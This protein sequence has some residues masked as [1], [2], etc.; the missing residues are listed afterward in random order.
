[1]SEESQ[2]EE[3]CYAPRNV[4]LQ[5]LTLILILAV[6]DNLATPLLNDVEMNGETRSAV[7]LLCSRNARPQKSLVGRA[8]WEANLR[9]KA[10]L[11]L[12]RLVASF[13]PE[14]WRNSSPCSCDC[15][16]L[17]VPMAPPTM[18]NIVSK[19]G[20]AAIALFIAFVSLKSCV[21]TIWTSPTE[22]TTYTVRGS[23][24][25]SLSLIFL[26]GHETLFLYTIESSNF[27]EAALTQ[28]RGTYGTHYFWRLWNIEGPG[29]AGGLFGYR[30]YPEGT[31]PV[32]ME[33]TVVKKF[34]HGTVQPTLPNEGE[35]TNP[36]ILFSDNAVHFG[37]MSLVKEPTDTNLV[38][39]L[40]RQLKPE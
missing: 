24:G 34:V 3:A 18:K 11:T 33:T 12:W 1:M 14:W 25:R 35:R 17:A 32:V 20:I 16:Q 27:V 37:G 10:R 31:E 26:P 36:V 4:G 2:T 6:K 13:R 22:P 23:D 19:F 30:L 39:D 28:M 38:Q 8:Q 40:L 15:T 21:V 5:D 29:I 7:G 9:E